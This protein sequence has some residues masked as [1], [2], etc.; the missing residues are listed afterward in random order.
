MN[1]PLLIDF[2][3]EFNYMVNG[4]TIW[5]T[6]LDPVASCGSVFEAFDIGDH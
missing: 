1:V 4:L 2:C 3:V 6:I 5:E